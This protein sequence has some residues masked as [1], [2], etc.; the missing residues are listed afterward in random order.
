MVKDVVPERRLGLESSNAS[1]TAASLNRDCKLRAVDDTSVL[2]PQDGLLQA[3]LLRARDYQT[4]M[5]EQSM[6]RNIIVA[7]RQTVNHSGRPGG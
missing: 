3:G 4:E 5:F 1:S 7:V 2:A 6:R